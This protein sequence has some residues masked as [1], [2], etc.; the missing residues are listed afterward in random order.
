MESMIIAGHAK[1][2]DATEIHRE[3]NVADNVSVD[4]LVGQA[5]GTFLQRTRI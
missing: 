5:Q 3:E 2:F 1:L 4:L